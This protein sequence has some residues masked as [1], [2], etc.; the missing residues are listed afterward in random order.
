MR[1]IRE[2]SLPVNGEKLFNA[3]PKKIHELTTIKLDYFK[4]ALDNIMTTVR[5]QEQLFG[6]T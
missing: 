1:K 3:P 5:D 6:Y 4:R 2:A